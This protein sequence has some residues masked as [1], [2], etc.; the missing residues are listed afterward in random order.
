MVTE[1]IYN[2]VEEVSKE[3]KKK[4]YEEIHEKYGEESASFFGSSCIVDGSYMRE[5]FPTYER[6]LGSKE[7][8]K[9]K[10]NFIQFFRFT[11]VMASQ[12]RIF[13][14]STYGSQSVYIK[15]LEKISE[16]IA[17]KTKKMCKEYR[18]LYEDE[19]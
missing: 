5:C 9:Y 13:E 18:E 11:R 4:M 19:D 8:E 12:H 3:E 16:I 1:K 7:W 10:D 2:S 14:L 17:D 6:I 15:P